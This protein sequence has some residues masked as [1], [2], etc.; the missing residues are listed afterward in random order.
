MK[1]FKTFFEGIPLVTSGNHIKLFKCHFVGH[2]LLLLGFCPFVIS[3]LI[4]TNN[5][6]KGLRKKS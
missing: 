2:S 4:Y 6:K 1:I 5:V 3:I